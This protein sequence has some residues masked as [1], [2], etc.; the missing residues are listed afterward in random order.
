[1]ERCI[2]SFGKVY[3]VMFVVGN[4]TGGTR[5]DA[6][7]V[8]SWVKVHEAMYVVMKRLPST[9]IC[10]LIGVGRGFVDCNRLLS[11]VGHNKRQGWFGYDM[12]VDKCRA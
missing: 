5:V 9:K 6:N 8:T 7:W 12:M 11:Y 3:E 10:K 4:R 2:C 1:M